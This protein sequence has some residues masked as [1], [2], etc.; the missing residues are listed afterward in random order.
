LSL[1]AAVLRR[2]RRASPRSVIASSGAALFVAAAAASL[3]GT[4]AAWYWMAIVFVI[5]I[6]RIVIVLRPWRRASAEQIQQRYFIAVALDALAWGSTPMWLTHQPG[7]EAVSI[8]LLAAAS[9]V[10][11]H[12]LQRPVLDVQRFGGAIWLLAGYV[13]M[14]LALALS[15]R[16]ELQWCALGMALLSTG[17]AMFDRYQQ[18]SARTALLARAENSKLVERLREQA[19]IAEKSNRDKTRFLAAAA[20]DLRQPL[21]ALG[22]FG[23]AIEK[24][25]RERPEYPLINSMMRSIESL[26]KSFT[27]LLD[28]SRLDAGAVKPAYQV[29]PVRD[30][31]RRIYMQYAGEAE[32]L[33]IS[34]RFRAAGKLV[35]S[36]P[37]LLERIV[38][39][40]VQNAL[41]YT[42]RGGVLVAARRAGNDVAIE[43][44][45]SGIG[46][47][48]EQMESIFQEFYQVDNI[49]RDRTKGIGMGLAIVQRLTALLEHRIDVRSQPGKGS[50][51]RVVI[52]ASLDG[53]PIT[54]QLG[55]DT[56]PPR[57]DRAL[58]VLLIDDEESIRRGMEEMFAPTQTRLIAAGT[59]AEAEQLVQHGAVSID[60]VISDLRLRGGENGVDVI[61]QLRRLY[62]PTLPAVLITGE[63]AG[64]ALQRAHED[65]IVVLFKP[66]QAKE[67]LRLINRLPA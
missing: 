20:H 59:L 49:E 48:P 14:V 40:L 42:E 4:R 45:D 67:I 66:V 22:L 17:H 29:F 32:R 46:I 15:K 58:T 36:D 56:L 13:P 26:E 54:A 53:M 11:V 43:V 55:A 12:A 5:D 31:F 6:A 33:D 1:D 19:G 25:L 52:P 30:L 3:T 60:F 51:F 8:A 38:S 39:N 28:I 64:D 44:W 57:I 27:A 62:G 2:L 10:G 63:T 34:L 41:R 65:G 50:I 16:I 35:R 9:L 61:A 37:M 47:P 23:A 7:S 24:R 18:R 21:H